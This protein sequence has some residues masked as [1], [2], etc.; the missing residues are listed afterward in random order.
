MIYNR[1]IEIIFDKET[2][3]ILDDQSKKCNWLYNKLLDIARE[4][5]N[6][7]NTLNLMNGRNLMDYVVKLKG[8]NPFLY[9]VHSSPLKNVA[10]RLKDSYVRFFR[11][12]S[13]I[14]HFRSYSQKWFSLYYDEAN[15]GF[16]L[17]ENKEIDISLGK[18]KVEEKDKKGN[19]KEKEKQLHI[20]GNLKEKLIYNKNGKI[21]TFRLCKDKNRF[22]GVFTIEEPDKELKRTQI[23][24]WISI[25]QNHKNFFVGV[26]YKGET[27][28]FERLYGETYFDKKIDL[29]KS[30]R[31]KCLK[32]AKEKITEY[33]NKYYIPSKRYK[34]LNLAL[35]R[36][37]ARRREQIKSNMYQIAHF[38]CKNYDEIII[39]NYVPSKEVAKFD[40]MRRSM[41]N[42]SH[43]GEFRNILKWV[44]EKSAKLCKIVDEKDT[45]KKCCVCGDIEKK[46]PEIREFICKKCNSKILRDVNSAI[47][48][49]KKGNIEINI[50]DMILDKIVH[51]GKINRKTE[52]KISYKLQII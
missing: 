40:T 18:I 50:N 8:E 51:I 38:L 11:G 30:K 27:Y 23:K 25:D 4:D 24:R 36:L 12:L 47:N 35:Q 22:Y 7:G 17:K 21:K 15:K 6:N 16:K 20:K 19:I 31:D 44:S 52:N 28:E 37:Y 42:Q 13:K 14:P 3:L 5:Y 43:I 39:G 46:P 26:D 10:I 33:G 34:R 45:T 2:K 9:S 32:R 29:V 49:A 41:L 1:K 48:I